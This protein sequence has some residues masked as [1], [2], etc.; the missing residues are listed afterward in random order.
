VLGGRP[1][2]L[3]ASTPLQSP[4]WHEPLPL[5]S[6]EQPVRAHRRPREV[7]PDTLRVHVLPGL[8]CTPPPMGKA[9]GHTV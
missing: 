6:N 1:W 2:P 3:Q 8:S 4:V 9:A 5:L 7:R